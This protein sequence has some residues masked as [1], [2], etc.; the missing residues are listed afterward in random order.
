VTD[1]EEYHIC[2][3]CLTPHHEDCWQYAGGCAIF[4]CRK[5][6]VKDAK[7]AESLRKV[8]MPVNLSLMSMW[9]W[10]NRFHMFLSLQISSSVF[11]L[12]VG[13]STYHI[14]SGFTAVARWSVKFLF[15]QAIISY[16]VVDY[17]RFG[18]AL[19]YHP[20]KELIIVVFFLCLVSILLGCIAYLL[21]LP[22]AIAM[23]IHFYLI[24]FTIPAGKSEVAIQIVDRLDMDKINRY[25]VSF[26]RVM[27][28]I[29]EILIAISFFETLFSIGIQGKTGRNSNMLAASCLFLLIVRFFAIPLF[30]LIVRRK[31]T[32]ILS[33]QNRLVVFYKY[34]KTVPT[35]RQIEDDYI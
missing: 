12:A 6:L 30:D 10:I 28:K 29:T 9:G 11:L 3:T 35:E 17:L 26:N 15:E 4:G 16:S 25:F 23:R 14:V 18:F 2:E 8:L 21:S 20:V 19:A 27:K 22:F 31:M 24:D 5:Q 34:S 33:F 32:F 7:G 1:K 13:T